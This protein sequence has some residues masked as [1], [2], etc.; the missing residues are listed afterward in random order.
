MVPVEPTI[1][2]RPDRAVVAAGNPDLPR[3]RAAGVMAPGDV[4]RMMRD[5]FADE[6]RRPPSGVTGFD[7]RLSP[8]FPG[9]KP[10]F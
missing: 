10:G 9:R 8:I 4:A 2:R 6:A 1:H 7:D 5:L 3:E